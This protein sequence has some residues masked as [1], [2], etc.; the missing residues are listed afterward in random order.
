MPCFGSLL[1]LQCSVVDVVSLFSR[2]PFYNRL[3]DNI[4]QKTRDHYVSTP[5][6]FPLL[7]GF[8]C[9]CSVPYIQWK[10]VKYV[11]FLAQVQMYKWG[12]QKWPKFR[13]LP[14]R[15]ELLADQK[16]I[17]RTWITFGTFVSGKEPQ[18]WVLPW[19]FS[20]H[21]SNNNLIKSTKEI[22]LIGV[23]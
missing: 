7:V 5:P 23:L 22:N 20:F 16:V 10:I 9:L 13:V 8:C 12:S 19:F 14:Q 6:T 15:C 4:F 21:R 1:P 18:F 17:N 2:H 3:L 11:S